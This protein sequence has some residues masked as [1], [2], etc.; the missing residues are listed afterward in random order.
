[1]V[2]WV[3]KFSK[4][5]Y[6]IFDKITLYMSCSVMNISV[7]PR[8]DGKISSKIC[9]AQCTAL[10]A[11]VI[12]VDKFPVERYKNLYFFSK[13][14]WPSV[15]KNCSWFFFDWEKHWKIEVEGLKFF[16]ITRTI[17]SD[18]ERSEQSSKIIFLS[19]FLKFF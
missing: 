10:V 4:E 5:G 1:M 19:L 8:F 7:T 18:V 11:M 15:I 6:K 13:L 3:V 17:Y 14:F 9:I 16:K 12:W 2:I